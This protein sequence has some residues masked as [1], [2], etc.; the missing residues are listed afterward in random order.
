MHG[1]ASYADEVKA[2]T[3]KGECT[4]FIHLLR[5]CVKIGK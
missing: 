4:E 1:V 3:E 2:L 5:H